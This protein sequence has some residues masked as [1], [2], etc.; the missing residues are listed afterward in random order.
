MI[1]FSCIS[2]AKPKLF[3]AKEFRLTGGI[4]TLYYLKKEKYFKVPEYIVAKNNSSY[5]NVINYK[6]DNKLGHL[7]SVSG[8]P[9]VIKNNLVSLE[10]ESG[11]E[12]FNIKRQN[13]INTKFNNYHVNAILTN[14][15]NSFS[16]ICNY[17]SFNVIYSE[18]I[19]Q[20]KIS[21]AHINF[22]RYTVAFS[23]ETS[24]SGKY[25]NWF[26]YYNPDTFYFISIGKKFNNKNFIPFSFLICHTIPSLSVYRSFSLNFQLF[27]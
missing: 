15:S 12:L 4:N 17:F 26:Q 5:S 27:L 20:G 21:F 18:F 22:V 8:F 25:T 1:F 14:T 19:L 7:V 10:L 16:Q 13:S 24:Y 9:L 11:I 6:N 3:F 23:D 2:F